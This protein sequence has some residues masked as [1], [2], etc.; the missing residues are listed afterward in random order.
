VTLWSQISDVLPVHCHDEFCGD[1]LTK[2]LLDNKSDIVG[3]RWTICDGGGPASTRG[4]CNSNTETLDFAIYGN[5]V[6][7]CR[8]EHY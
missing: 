7:N 1:R 5:D 4:R 3:R 8:L 6:E 2:F